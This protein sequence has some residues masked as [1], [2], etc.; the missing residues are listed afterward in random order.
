VGGEPGNGFQETKERAQQDAT[1]I[2][3][4]P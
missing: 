4:K 2:L 1:M 3:D